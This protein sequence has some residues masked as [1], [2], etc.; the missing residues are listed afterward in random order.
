[1]VVEESGKKKP[2]GRVEG[3]EA[4]KHTTSKCVG[5]FLHHVITH[6]YHSMDNI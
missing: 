6:H 2:T 4:M 3:Q 1:M 5:W